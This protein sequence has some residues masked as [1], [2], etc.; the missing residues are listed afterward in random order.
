MRNQNTK[1]TMAFKPTNKS[2][3]KDKI[4]K[5]LLN[6][7]VIRYDFREEKPIEVMIR[8]AVPYLS[9]MHNIG[10][11]KDGVVENIYCDHDILH[12]IVS[13][14]KADYS[15]RKV[16][17]GYSGCCQYSTYGIYIDGEE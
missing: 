17:C 7:Y 3:I 4:R 11:E 2:S 8:D 12:N 14:L 16:W 15:V 5:Y 9:R 1:Y 6:G 13:E 10:M